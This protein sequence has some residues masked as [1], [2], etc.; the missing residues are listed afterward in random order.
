MLVRLVCLGA[1]VT[2]AGMAGGQNDLTPIAPADW[3]YDFAAHLLE[4]AGFGGTPEEIA[5][6]GENDAR[7]GRR[8]AGPLRRNRRRASCLPST[9]P[10]STIPD[11]SRFLP[12]A[13][14]SPTWRRRKAKRSA[15]KSSRPAT[16]ACS[17]S[18]TSSSTGC[19][20][21]LL[22]TNRVAYWW[23]NRML[24]SPRPLQEK[25][26]LFWHGHFAVERS[27][28][29]RLPQAPGPAGALPE[30]GHWAISAT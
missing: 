24:T 2:A 6:A 28:G 27:Q 23:A 10:A 18:S 12:A 17:P 19:A 30:T 25:M 14:P 5:G 26:A 20:P 15:S 8:A 16:A 1:L 13:R 22:E 11:S 7:A 4:R 9:I 3:N 29:A 21:A